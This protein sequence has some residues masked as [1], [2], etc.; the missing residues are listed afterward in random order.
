MSCRMIQKPWNIGQIVEISFLCRHFQML[1]LGVW[2]ELESVAK[3]LSL[4]QDLATSNGIIWFA[5]AKFWESFVR[6]LAFFPEL[7][8]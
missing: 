6:M 7:H 3:Q 4:I 1:P 5:F 8:Y 2:L